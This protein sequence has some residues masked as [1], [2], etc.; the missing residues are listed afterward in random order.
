MP[1]TPNS[2]NLSTTRPPTS[3]ELA[4]LRLEFAHLNHLLERSTWKPLASAPKGKILLLYMSTGIMIQGD[5]NTFGA[6]HW[7]LKP[8]SPVKQKE[9]LK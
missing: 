6:T 4:E 8:L 3:V 5:S 2:I 7:M 1:L 9:E